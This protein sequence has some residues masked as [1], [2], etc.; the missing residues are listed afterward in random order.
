M[1]WKHNELKYYMGSIKS[2]LLQ[3]PDHFLE[4]RKYVLNIMDWGKDKCLKEIR[5]SLDSLLE[6][7]RK[8]A[9]RLAKSRPPPS[10][11]SAS[12]SSYKRKNPLS[13]RRDSRAKSVPKYPSG[14]ANAPPFTSFQENNQDDPFL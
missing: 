13:R 6:E 4:F 5:D 9:S 12:S 7:D 14:R 11:D 10:D 3:R 8:M 2:F 1:S